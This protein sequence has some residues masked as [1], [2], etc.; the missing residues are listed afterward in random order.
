MDSLWRLSAEAIAHLVRTRAVSASAVAR[1]ALL[2]LEAV[3]PALN[4]VVAYSPEAVI[5][6]AE[7]LDAAIA[8][9][10]A[11]GGLL[12]VPV[13][14]KVNTDQ[15]GL[16]STN[17]LVLQRDLVATDDN[18]VVA[19]LRKAGAIILGR[20]NT[21]AF[22][23]RWFTNNRL[24]GATRN[25]RDPA[26]TPGGSS[27][28]AA[29]AVASGIGAIAHG[30]DIAG[31]IRYPA[32]AC[33]IHGLRPTLGRI[34]AYNPSQP[35]RAIGGQLMAT[36][37]PLARTIGDLKL[38]LQ[39]M[40]R[41]D[42]RDPWW[43]P[44]PLVGP[45]VGK[46]VALCIR[47]DGLATVP[48]VEAAL[49]DSA[50][51]LEQ[52]GWKVEPVTALPPLR[53]AADLQVLLWIADGYADKLRD[54]ERE[55]DPG[56]WAVLR[57]LEPM[58]RGFDLHAFSRALTR[59]AGLMRQWL[60]FFEETPL[61]LL[62]VSGELP[63]ADDADRDGAEGFQRVWRAQMPQIATPFLGLPGLTVST[64]MVGRTPVGV[65]LI[66]AKF[67]EDLL[68]EAGAAI[69]AGGVPT[70]PIDPVP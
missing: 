56:A 20:T 4:A 66:A 65:Q 57:G 63:F 24:H 27:G 39:A 29:A 16:A 25:P 30:T 60:L 47:P 11:S 31:S 58:V 23:Y 52:A 3:N 41:G 6:E 18:P 15:A 17:G 38:A 50:R 53:E 5:G 14:I 21:P 32:Y 7:A 2:R 12:G 59:R 9:G 45:P 34:A 54:A 62:P 26:L 42:A 13:T 10:E 67:R 69:E 46:R 44:A 49:L 55:D 40:A 61:V 28:G 37:G 35:E 68:L 48:A 8:R 1:D 64:G 19:N 70:A 43:V 33:G 51:R 22:S 36:S